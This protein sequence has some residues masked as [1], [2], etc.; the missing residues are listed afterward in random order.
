MMK[1][2]NIYL[3][4][5][6]LVFFS[7]EEV[8]LEEDLSDKTILINAPT[9]GATVRNTSVTFNWE[10]VDQATA[11][12]LQVAQ[13]DFENAAQ[14]VLDTTITGTSFNTSL[15]RNSYN[16]R[17]RGQN[18]G[19]ATP[20]VTAGFTVVESEDFSA[21]EVL[22]VTPGNTTIVNTTSINLQWQAVTDATSYRIQLLN[23]SNA[24]VEEKTTADTSISFTFPEGVTQW[25]VR[26]E[27]NTQNTLYTTRSLTVDSMKPNQ[28]VV[29]APAN[30]VSQAGTTV[31][32]SWT[33]EAVAGTPEFDSIY[34]YSDVALTQLVSKNRVT[35]PTDIELDASTT[36]YWFLKAFDEAENESESSTSS[37]FTIN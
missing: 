7:C 3:G 1:R 12:R 2:I 13:P 15:V 22:L 31:T 14:I 37:R 34:I 11:Y 20:Y 6:F 5:V 30:D 27:N 18:S 32:F 29:V 21:R 26:A 16:W 24:V 8:L 4:I 23:Q 35:S 19:T 10:T 17:V 9:D 36:Y 25:Q 33:R 28:P